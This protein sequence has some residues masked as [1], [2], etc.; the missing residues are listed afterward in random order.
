MEKEVMGIYVSDHPL[1]G[2]ERTIMANATHTCAA[3]LELEDGVPV[4]LAGVLAKLRTIVTKS[5]GK[6]MA[7]F[8]MEDFTGQAGA[9]VFPGN[10]EKLKDILVKDSVVQVSGFVMHR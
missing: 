3:A 9:I 10:Y 1:R 8:V 6:R 4:K 2:H 7:S 5:E